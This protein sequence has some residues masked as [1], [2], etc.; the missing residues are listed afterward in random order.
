MN[1]I[2]FIWAKKKG[3]RTEK[4]KLENAGVSSYIAL[5]FLYSVYLRCFT[6]C[7]NLSMNGKLRQIEVQVCLAKTTWWSWYLCPDFIVWHQETYSPD[8]AKF[9]WSKLENF[10]S[11]SPL[12]LFRRNSVRNDCTFRYWSCWRSYIK[13]CFVRCFFNCT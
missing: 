5:S 12:C 6:N 7:R 4:E 2:H 9:L 8:N 13:I 1:F 3:S 10:W 11:V